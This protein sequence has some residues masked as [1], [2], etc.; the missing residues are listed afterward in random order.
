M[1]TAKCI[2][3]FYE[4]Y[5]LAEFKSDT[6]R[7]EALGYFMAGCEIISNNYEFLEYEAEADEGDDE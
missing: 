5:P 3:K 7:A 6:E 1:N 2:N 4:R